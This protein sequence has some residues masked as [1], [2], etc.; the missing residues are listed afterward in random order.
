[1]QWNLIIERKKQNLSQDDLA[2]ILN[3]SKD[4]YGRKERGQLQFNQDE[5]F[6]LSEY[7]GKTVEEIFLPRNCIKNAQ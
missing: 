6:L 3:I 1:M 2:K 4:T 5:M 7:F